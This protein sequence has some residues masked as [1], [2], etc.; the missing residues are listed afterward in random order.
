[1]E[2]ESKDH[3]KLV[4]S[5]EDRM[6]FVDHGKCHDI[7]SGEVVR[8]NEQLRI[9]TASPRVSNFRCIEIFWDESWL[10]WIDAFEASGCSE[11]FIRSH[12]LVG[13][14]EFAM[15]NVRET[16]RRIGVLNETVEDSHTT[17]LPDID[18]GSNV[19]E[20]ASVCLAYVDV[21]GTKSAAKK[22]C[23]RRSVKQW[24][25]LARK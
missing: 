7:I 20:A 22:V 8:T 5:M 10:K 18:S 25:R 1:M 12:H 21:S 14:D 24:W 17:K 15:Q 13:M 23:Y 19:Y 4:S 6:R 3:L 16:L 2:Y 9:L 11:R